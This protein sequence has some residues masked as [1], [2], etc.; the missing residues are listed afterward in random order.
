MMIDL[1]D[2]QKIHTF[3]SGWWTCAAACSLPVAWSMG[4]AATV[5]F[6]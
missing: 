1:I 5:E 2:R 4:K 3:F 6:Q